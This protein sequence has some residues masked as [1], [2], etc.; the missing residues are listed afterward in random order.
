[1]DYNIKY[2]FLDCDNVIAQC[3]EENLVKMLYA[4][5]KFYIDENKYKNLKMYEVVENDF[6]FIESF[7]KYNIDYYYEDGKRY[8]GL[9]I[10]DSNDKTYECYEDVIVPLG[11]EI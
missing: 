4:I 11:I 9:I 1:M 5:T 2:V 7:T 8:L 10:K 6:S 3:D